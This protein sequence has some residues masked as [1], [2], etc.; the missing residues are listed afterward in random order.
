[1]SKNISRWHDNKLLDQLVVLFLLILKLQ[2][3]MLCLLFVILG[4]LKVLLEVRWL[5][6]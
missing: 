2:I 5:V 6:E 1:M 4:V 3:L